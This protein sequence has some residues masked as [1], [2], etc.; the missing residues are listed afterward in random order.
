MNLPNKRTTRVSLLVCV[1]S[2][3]LLLMQADFRMFNG[4]NLGAQ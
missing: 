1:L 2:E 3:E 4:L